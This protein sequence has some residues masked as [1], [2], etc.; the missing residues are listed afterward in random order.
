MPQDI[1]KNQNTQNNE[2]ISWQ[3]PEFIHYEKTSDWYWGLGIITLALL[4]GAILLGNFLFGILLLIGGFSLSLYGAKKP[5]TVQFIIDSRGI[6]IN[7]NLYTYDNLNSFWINN[8]NPEKE[9]LLIESK[10]TFMP[11]ISIALDNVNSENVRQY[12]LKNLK[13]EKKELSL[14]TAIAKILRF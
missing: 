6:T 11:Q 8:L 14:T 1:I 10:K 5:D 7:K 9:E 13:E 4:I 12:L 3:A 2:I